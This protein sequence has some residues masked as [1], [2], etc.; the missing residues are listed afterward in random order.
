MRL[1]VGD[2]RGRAVH[3]PVH[4]GHV[5][6]W[7]RLWTLCVRFTGDQDRPSSSGQEAYAHMC[8]TVVG[9]EAMCPVWVATKLHRAATQ[10]SPMGAHPLPGMRPLWP[11]V[12]R[13]F[14]SK[15]AVTTTFQ[16]LAE[17]TAIDSQVTGHVCRVTGAQAMAVAGVDVWVGLQS[18]IGAHS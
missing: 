18:C 13:K 15:R 8:S 7:P 3:R 14:V 2:A 10:H 12:R 1:L 9:S 6:G 16:R 11:A 5:L 4:A 17:L